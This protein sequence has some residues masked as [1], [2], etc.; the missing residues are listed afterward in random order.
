MHYPYLTLQESKI[1]DLSFTTRISSP[2]ADKLVLKTRDQNL[3]R[4]YIFTIKKSYLKN[5]EQFLRWNPIIFKRLMLLKQSKSI[6]EIY[7]KE[8]KV[9]TAIIKHRSLKR[10]LGI[11]K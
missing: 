8:I 3:I 10:R 11:N 5:A 2:Q 4:I 6:S 1:V 9:N 7:E